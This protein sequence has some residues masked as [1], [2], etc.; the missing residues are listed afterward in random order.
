M[1][2]Q[3]SIPDESVPVNP[4]HVYCVTEISLNLSYNVM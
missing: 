3:V 2:S 1:D 4:N